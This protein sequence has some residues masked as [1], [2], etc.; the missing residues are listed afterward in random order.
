MISI[1]LWL[2]SDKRACHPPARLSK[3]C[4]ARCPSAATPCPCSS[5]G[6]HRTT[7]SQ[8]GGIRLGTQKASLQL[9]RH[10]TLQ[11][12]RKTPQQLL[13]RSLGC[14]LTTLGASPGR[15]SAGAAVCRCRRG[16]WSAPQ[17]APPSR[18]PASPGR[19]TAWSGSCRQAVHRH[20]NHT[21]LW[22]QSRR[23]QCL[24][25]LAGLATGLLG[26][27]PPPL[28]HLSKRSR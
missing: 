5:A 7:Q 11:Q 17:S 9:R 19:R 26:P 1:A 2:W 3:S 18:A 10:C 8:C 22:M 6:H 24:Y 28:A 16:R 15:L 25:G 21:E 14:R 4:S 12:G 23:G 13:A 27:R 20:V